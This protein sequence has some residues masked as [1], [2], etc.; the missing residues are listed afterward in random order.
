MSKWLA[1]A[2]IWSLPL[3]A[4]ADRALQPSRPTLRQAGPVSALSAM[5]GEPVEIDL[6]DA[7]G[8]ALR[9][10]RA[11]RSAYLERVAQKFDLRV[12]HDRFAPQLSLKAR[13]L[14]NRNHADRYREAQ[15]APSAS[16]LT[17]YGTRLSLDWDYGH[18]RADSAGRRYRD[19]ASLMIVQP[20]LRGAGREIASA[21][22]RQATLAEQSN[23]LALADDVAQVITRTLLSYRE[24]LRAQE[25]LRIAEDSLLRAR[26]LVAVSH[27]LIAAG[28]MAAFEVVQAEAEVASQEL[29]VEGSRN[30]LHHSR[31]ALAQLLALDLA[32]PLR[33]AERLLAERWQVSTEQALARAEA[34][35][36]TY[37]MQQLATE[38]AAIALQVAS[39]AQWWD[40][41]L[42]GGASQMHQ[43]PGNEAAWEHYLGLELEVPIG[44]LSRRQAQVRAQVEVETQR[45]GL[46]ESRQQLERDVSTAIR[47]L[48]VRWRQLEIAGRALALT[49]RKL[50]I[51]QQKLAA[52]RSSNFQVLSFESD[53]RQAQS[54]QL[55]ATIAYLDAQVVLDQVV[56]TTLLKWQVSLND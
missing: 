40:L 18:T 33:A 43:R 12:A 10:N 32:T 8:L 39:N 3:L 4:M 7:V 52:G 15:L 22:L 29:T 54:T 38:Q 6:A 47:D 23:R 17:P 30:Q 36:P 51:E 11:I 28:R 1:M 2:C 42:V 55:E 49:R 45:L 9:D 13:Y 35:Q 20:L 56:G 25:Q 44:D 37:L 24:L 50:D 21:P 19:G 14:G 41:S 5:H 16:L 53:L 27:A 46:V 48:Q 26:Q 31:V 34:L